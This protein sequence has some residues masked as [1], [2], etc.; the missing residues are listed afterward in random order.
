M[1]DSTLQQ[2]PNVQPI[3]ATVR[4]RVGSTYSKRL[5][6]GGRLPAVIYGRDGDSVSIHMDENEA[7]KHLNR[8]FRVFR[9][10]FEGGDS[11]DVKVQ[12]FQFGHLGDNLLHIDFV[13]VDLNEKINSDVP[14]RV[15]GHIPGAKTIDQPLACIEV[16]AS[17]GVMPQS[18]E[19]RGDAATEGVITASS[20]VL[21]A[22][23]DLVTDPSAVVAQN[24]ELAE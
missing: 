21:P 14:V 18:L 16:A 24:S 4:D 19:V 7:M 2:L 13:R 3:D 9:I 6:E 22:G 5:R 15:V 1:S 8:G 23:V 20:V 10:A 12:E 17:L 11:Q